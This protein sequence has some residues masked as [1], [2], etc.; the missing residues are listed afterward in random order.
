MQNAVDLTSYMRHF[1]P[2][3]GGC[4]RSMRMGLPV[5]WEA[6]R[7]WIGIAVSCAIGL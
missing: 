3:A 6:A 4:K 1:E 2:P 7:H 5:Y